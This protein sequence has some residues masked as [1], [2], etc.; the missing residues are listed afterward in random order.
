MRDEIRQELIQEGVAKVLASA[1]EGL[2]IEKFNQDGTPMTTPA[3]DAGD[4]ARAAHRQP[5]PRPPK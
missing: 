4:P 5:R 1:K 2:Q 3:G